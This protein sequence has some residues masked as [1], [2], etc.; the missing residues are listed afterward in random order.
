[1]WFGPS[2]RKT[3]VIRWTN[4]CLQTLITLF[5]DTMFY[6]IF[7]PPNSAC[8]TYTTKSSCYIPKSMTDNSQTLCYWTIDTT[9]EYEGYCQLKAPPSE[10][11]FLMVIRK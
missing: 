9:V 7:Y 4:M 3:R 6:N 1:M 8:T 2:L 5:I 11:T 10:F